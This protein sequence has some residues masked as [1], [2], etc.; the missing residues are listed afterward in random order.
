MSEA[1]RVAREIADELRYND[2]TEVW[3]TV[4]ERRIAA[5]I[6]EVVLA[7]RERCI[8]AIDAA[9]LGFATVVTETAKEL[10]RGGDDGRARGE[11][12]P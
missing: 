3:E 8:G 6:N 4:I 11:S 10:I 1:E 12:K 2:G 7:E 5:A 9:T